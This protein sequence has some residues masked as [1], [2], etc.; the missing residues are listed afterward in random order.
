MLFSDIARSNELRR[1]VVSGAGATLIVVMAVARLALGAHR[2]AVYF[3]I[4]LIACR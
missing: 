3:H 2:L 1:I 4:R